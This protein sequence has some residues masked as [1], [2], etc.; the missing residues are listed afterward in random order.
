V[1]DPLLEGRTFDCI[2]LL[3][4]LDRCQ[5]PLSLLRDLKKKLNPGGVVLIALVVPFSPWVETNSGYVRPTEYME[6]KSETFEETANKFTEKVL[7]P[8]GYQV[9]SLSK[10]PYLSQGDYYKELYSLTDSI[11]VIGLA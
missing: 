2:A 10:V 4:L 8:M 1:N 9:K 11:W 7:A 3:N 5:K 6:I